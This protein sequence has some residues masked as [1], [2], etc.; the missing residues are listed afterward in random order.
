MRIHIAVLTQLTL[1]QFCLTG[2]SLGV[3][4]FADK[5]P[6]HSFSFD[7][8][9]DSS[10]TEVLDYEYGTGRQFGTH[11]NQE[12]VAMGTDFSQWSTTGHMPRGDFL[13]VKWRVMNRK[14]PPEYA[15]IYEDRVD[16]RSRLPF[17]LT[18]YRVH[19]VIKGP[20]LYVYLIS[21]E[22]K[23]ASEPAGPVREYAAHKQVQIY[24]DQQK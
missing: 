6:F 10:D 17:N 5:Y 4:V 12:M 22:L 8:R 21:P 3:G 18:G 16:L 1:L 14:R 19:F 2:C 23:S 13:Y 9:H 15:D 24:P 7:T 11:A 20:Q